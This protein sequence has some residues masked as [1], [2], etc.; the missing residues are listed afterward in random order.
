MGIW[1]QFYSTMFDKKITYG[2]KVSIEFETI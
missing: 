2:I 1:Q